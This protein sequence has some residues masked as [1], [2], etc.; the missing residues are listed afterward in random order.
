MPLGYRNLNIYIW[1]NAIVPILSQ[2]GQTMHKM[3]LE[4]TIIPPSTNPL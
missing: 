4:G 3:A 2:L 1:I